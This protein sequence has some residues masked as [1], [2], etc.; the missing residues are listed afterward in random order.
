M[1]TKKKSLLLITTLLIAVNLFTVYQYSLEQFRVSR[2]VTS[3]I[4]LL[5]FSFYGGIKKRLLFYAL[6]S[7]FV[8]DMFVI[9]YD[10]LI[11]N[12][13]TS[14]AATIG[15]LLIGFYLFPKFKLSSVKKR[16]VAIF[17]VLV[18]I[19]AYM[20]YELIG[21]M[22]ITLN[23]DLHRYV[24]Y[25]YSLVL[26]GLLVLVGNYNFRYNSTQSTYCM[27]FVFALVVS[28]LFAAI[29]YYLGMPLFYYPTRFFYVIGLGLLTA[30]AVLPF[31]KELLL[32]EEQ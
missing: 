31:E 6:L 13:L 7:F 25:L 2:S 12:N 22:A 15:Y 29:S 19:S 10:E 3:F 23:N 9:R 5:V 21:L 4:F 26:L 11:Y 24:Y 17:V 20:F 14:V 32:E 30:F 1:L 28:N 16:I 8:S 27:L 18:S